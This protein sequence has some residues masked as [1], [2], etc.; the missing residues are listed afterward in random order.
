MK[1]KANGKGKVWRKKGKWWPI[2]GNPNKPRF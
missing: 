2:N 1:K